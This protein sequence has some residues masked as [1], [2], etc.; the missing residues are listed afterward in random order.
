MDLTLIYWSSTH[1][2]VW[3]L[4]Y[5]SLFSGHAEGDKISLK[6]YE[7]MHNNGIQVDTMATLAR[8]GPNVN[9][10]ISQK[11]NELISQDCP[12]YEDLI[13]IGSCK[14]HTAHNA[15]GKDIEQYCKDIY[16]ICLDLQSKQ[17]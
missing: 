8:D 11:M 17:V 2:E 1:N 12:E 7:Q 5:T 14:I 16:Q 4:F 9:K 15:F 10:T 13:D 3:T 6:M